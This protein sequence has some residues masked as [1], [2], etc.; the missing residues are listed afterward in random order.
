[1]PELISLDDNSRSRL[2]EIAGHGDCYK[3]AALHMSAE[4]RSSKIRPALRGGANAGFNP[5]RP[6]DHFKIK[7]LR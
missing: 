1:V 4:P 5:L 2:S 6:A 7:V 3:I